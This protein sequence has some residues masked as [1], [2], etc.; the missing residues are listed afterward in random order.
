[1]RI[2]L[3]ILPPLFL[4]LTACQKTEWAKEA[5]ATPARSAQAPAQPAEAAS[6]PPA[7]PAGA[8][9]PFMTRLA[10]YKAR[11]EKN[12][13]DIEAIVFLGNANFDIQRYEKAKEFY[14]GALEIDPD[15]LYIRTDLASSYRH[16]GDYD[17]ALKEL[18]TV[19]KA[20]PHHE[21]AL[22][23]LGVIYV[24]DKKDPQKGAAAWTRLI[25][26]K[27]D[28]PLSQELQKKIDEIKESE[29]TRKP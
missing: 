29:S 23:N 27:P 10:E 5:V 6:P 20:D 12:P 1:M 4:T 15:N 8:P 18:Q 7:H 14:L 24:N 22:Y 11:L 13:R 3:L 16:L 19:L 26:L 25:K 17:Q 21:V 9:V 2:Y 28:D